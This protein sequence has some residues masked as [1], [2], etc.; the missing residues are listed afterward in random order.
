MAYNYA[1]Y[2]QLMRHAE[3]DPSP[4][5]DIVVSYTEDSITETATGLFPDEQDDIPNQSHDLDTGTAD[6]YVESD[7]GT[8]VDNESVTVDF[9]E[10]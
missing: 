2:I 4:L 6:P 10:E 7:Q 5:P 8:T 9:T 1:F 3:F